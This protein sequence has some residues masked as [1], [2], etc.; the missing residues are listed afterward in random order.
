MA[1]VDTYVDFSVFYHWPL[2]IEDSTLLK[3]NILKEYL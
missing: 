2:L 1:V 3:N